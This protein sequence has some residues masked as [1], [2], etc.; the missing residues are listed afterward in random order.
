VHTAAEVLT[1][2]VKPSN[3]IETILS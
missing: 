1:E 3:Q 2:G